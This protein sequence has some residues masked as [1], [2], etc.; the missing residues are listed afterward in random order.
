M[1]TNLVNI[2]CSANDRGFAT[3]VDG[4]MI[5]YEVFGNGSTTLVFVHGGCCNRTHW[6]NQVNHFR[7]N[8]RV[9]VLDLGGHGKSGQNRNVWSIEKFGD[10]V[11]CVIKKLKLRNVILVGHSLGGDVI[12]E[13]ALKLKQSV[14]ALIA[15]DRFHEIENKFTKEYVD[16]RLKPLKENFVQGMNDFS[17]PWLFISTTD[18]TLVDKI[19][20]D[21]TSVPPQIG[22]GVLENFMT[23]D[24]TISQ[25]E[26]LKIP[27]RFINCSSPP[28]HIE[29]A[30]RHIKDLKVK[31]MENVG[32]FV[33]LED[34]EKFN[35]ILDDVL[36]EIIEY[37]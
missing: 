22:I 32:H 15:I 5:Y 19:M 31:I 24:K 16:E 25:F 9:V 12:L 8:F 18:S 37:G 10:D 2:G 35:R 4:V 14:K 26:K 36:S 28:T 17:R 27:V 6:G 30:N 1:I 33:M 21:M 13:A 29:S 23:Y 7:K 11:V 20:N 3:S 34:P